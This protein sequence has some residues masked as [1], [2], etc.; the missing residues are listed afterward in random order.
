MT[1]IRDE[2]PADKGHVLLMDASRNLGQTASVGPEN[3]DL[4]GAMRLQ[5][6]LAATLARFFHKSSNP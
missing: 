3:I 1:T 2:R 4:G 5:R 6:L